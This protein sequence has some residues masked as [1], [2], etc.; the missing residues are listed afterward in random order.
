MLS[1]YYRKDIFMKNVQDEFEEEEFSMDKYVEEFLMN[2][3]E[4]YNLE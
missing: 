2:Q 3:E 4:Q 1:E